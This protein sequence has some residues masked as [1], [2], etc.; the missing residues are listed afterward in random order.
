MLLYSTE[1]HKGAEII[2]SP[3]TLDHNNEQLCLIN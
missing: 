1:I 2:T 3:D